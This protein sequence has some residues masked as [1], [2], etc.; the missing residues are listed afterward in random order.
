MP[1]RPTRRKSPP[2]ARGEAPPS[3]Q[4][5]LFEGAAPV[6]EAAPALRAWVDGGARGNPGP[7]GYGAYV[8]DEDGNVVR[9]LSGFLGVTT[10]NVAEYRGLLAALTLANEL[11][12]RSLVVHADSELVVKQM[13][14][15]YKVKHEKLKPLFLQAQA[16]AA[17]LPKFT[18]RH[19]RRE[20]NRDADR[21]ANEAMDRG[22]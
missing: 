10:N 19:V 20:Q 9:E 8:T 11:E 21:L 2:A 17:R 15:Q 4:G 5:S 13:N 14:G 16:L 12:A 7:A 1:V 18:I 3:R 22:I 6:V